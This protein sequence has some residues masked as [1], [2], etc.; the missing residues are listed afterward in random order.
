MTSARTRELLVK[1][2]AITTYFW[3]IKVLSTTVGET[4]ADYLNSTLGFGLTK[5]ALIMTGALAIALVA[6]ISSTRYIPAIY[7]VTIVLISTVGTL[8]TDTL[9]DNF[10]VQNW[11]SIIVFATALILTFAIWHKREGSLE[12]K[13]INTRKREGFYWLAILFTFALGTAGGDIFLDDF[14]VAL[15]FSLVGFAIALAIVWALWKGKRINPVGAFW[16]AYVLTRPLG[17]AAGDFLS[18]PRDETGLGLGATTTSL[19]FLTLIAALVTYLT[20]SKKD[21]LA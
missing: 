21:R 4:L 1:V 17:A 7:W 13:S 5:T 10:N 15:K 14:G 12:M 19:I 9:H 3:I 16:V 20:V 6:Q 8:L 11:Q 18:L 2:P